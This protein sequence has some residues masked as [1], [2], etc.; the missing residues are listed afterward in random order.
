[1]LLSSILE[2]EGNL[3]NWSTEL[4]GVIPK[5]I[6]FKAEILFLDL[7]LK[8][9]S[10][11]SIVEELQRRMPEMEIIIISAHNG[12][13][14]LNQARQVGIEHFLSKPLNKELILKTLEQI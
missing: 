12:P 1:M 14:E 9:G 2:R 13:A 5:I 6:E 11:F 3:C 4:A 8:D 10:G 7:S